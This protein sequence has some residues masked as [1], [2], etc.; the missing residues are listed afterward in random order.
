VE[1]TTEAKTRIDVAEVAIIS[2]TYRAVTVGNIRDG[3]ADPDVAAHLTGA[4]KKTQKVK[5]TGSVITGGRNAVMI[6][7]VNLPPYWANESYSKE[8]L[9]L[10]I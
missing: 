5:N 6:H 2:D 4:D 3:E 7:A 8:E 9:P 10:R 1:L